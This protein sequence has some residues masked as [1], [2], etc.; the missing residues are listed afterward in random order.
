MLEEPVAIEITEFP[1][2]DTGA[3]CPLVL[4]DE[5]R[6]VLSYLLRDFP[7]DKLSA[8]VSFESVRTHS[9]GSPSDETQHGHPLW[10]KGLKH[11]GVFKIER[12][13]LIHELQRI[14]SVHPHHRTDVFQQ[15]NH[16]I[17][18]MHDSTFECVARSF[19]FAT[20]DAYSDQDRAARMIEGLKANRAGFVPAYKKVRAN[21]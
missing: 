21:V 17:V 13:P 15:L 5:H 3:P 6:V 19:H 11:Y 14:D 18:M 16:Y 8:I 4:A 7:D 2:M 1:L 10:G 20:S 9:L 12:S